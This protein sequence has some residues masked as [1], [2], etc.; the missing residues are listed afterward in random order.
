MAYAVAV[1][2]VAREG[3]EEA[4]RTILETF[5]PIVRREPACRLF[6]VHRA[7]DDPRTFYL[8][9]QYDDEAGFQ[10]HTA[11]DHFV[12]HILGD[13]VPR[14]EIRVREFYETLDGT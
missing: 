5:A 10:A 9:E 7:P 6:L 3:E 4:V 11:T 8:Y 14:L 13:A 1:K 12:T 2:W